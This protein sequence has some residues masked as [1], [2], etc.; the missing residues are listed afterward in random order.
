[1]Y[2]MNVFKNTKI[3]RFWG[4][5][6]QNKTWDKRTLV[7]RVPA[8][9]DCVALAQIEFSQSEHIFFFVNCQNN[10]KAYISVK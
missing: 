9:N 4:Q 10:F 3:Q 8:Y 5:S 2:V 1:M 6:F 7:S